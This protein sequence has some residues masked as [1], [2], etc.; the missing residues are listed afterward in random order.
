METARK[1]QIAILGSTGSI[2]TQTLQVVEEHPECFEVYAITANTRVD[3]LIAQA[4]KFMPEAVVIADETKYERLKEALDDLPI[5]VY[6][7]YES[8]CQI[9]ESAPIDIVVTAMVGFSGLRPTINA[10]KAGKAIA[11]A[12]KET[13]VVAGELINALAIEH[14]TP[15][16]PVDSE[17]SAIFQCLAGEM[18]NKVEKLILTASGGPFRTFTKEQLEHV[19][20]EQALKHPNWSMGAKITIDSASMMNKGFEVMEA[21]WLFGVGAQDIEVVVHPQSVIH[22]M[23]QFEDGAIKA[24]L[25]TPDMRLPI[26][27]ALTYPSRL[28]SSFGRLD[29]S[30]IKEFTFEKPNLE[31]FPNLRLAY[32][33]LA[34]GGNIPCVVNAANE[35]C[36]AAFLNDRIK[37]TD[38]PRLIERAMDEAAYIFK[39]TLDDYLETDKEIRRQVEE[40]IK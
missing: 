34:K 9:V 26:M 28:P 8:I 7:G 36:V 17:H 18:H 6:A 20:K 33:A 25:G 5:K 1:R 35:V 14:K 31:V 29:W 38:M 19:T 39:P 27:Y 15:I 13:M 16:L 23:V 32:E 2:G 10:I 22:S 30:N 3:E 11:L 4:R 21:K 37:F 40:W 24:Q 12:N